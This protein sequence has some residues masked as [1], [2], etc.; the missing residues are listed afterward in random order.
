MQYV[1]ILSS[2]YRTTSYFKGFTSFCF[3]NIYNYT[4]DVKD[5]IF[6]VARNWLVDRLN[7]FATSPESLVIDYEPNPRNNTYSDQPLKSFA[8]AH[9]NADLK[10]PF[11]YVIEGGGTR[12]NK[13]FH[14]CI[15]LKQRKEYV[16]IIPWNSHLL[17]QPMTSFSVAFSI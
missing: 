14:I 11:V 5:Y 1:F 8:Q 15:K 16:C 10:T 17:P 13:V 12:Q 9:P 7:S 2:V 4:S 3:V 6:A